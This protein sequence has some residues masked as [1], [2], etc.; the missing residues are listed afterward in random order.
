MSCFKNDHR[1]GIT[2]YMSYT[3]NIAKIVLIVHKEFPM[4]RFVFIMNHPATPAQLEAARKDGHEVVE[5]TNE[6]RKLLTVPDDPSLC[7]D[8]FYSQSVEILRTVG[9]VTDGDTVHVMGQQQLALA[10][11]ALARRCGAALVESVTPRVSKEFP[12]PDGSVKKENVFTFTGFRTV[13]SY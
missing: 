6:Q 11:S 8:W 10:V 2:V 12:Q 7:R 1:N 13:H 9:G 5:L 3:R 4:K